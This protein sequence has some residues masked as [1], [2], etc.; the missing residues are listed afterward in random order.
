M[1]RY[2]FLGADWPVAITTVGARLKSAPFS[3]ETGDGFI[4]DRIR[5]DFVEGRHF[6][7]I[8][9]IEVVETPFGQQS[10]YER[11]TYR[12]VRF[13]LS[14][15]YPQIEMLNPPRTARTF[16]NRLAQTLDFR[17][18]VE[19]LTVSPIEW[20]NKMKRSM[21][22]EGFV[23]T[24][25]ISDLV[26]D[27]WTT[28]KIGLSGRRDVLETASKLIAKRRHNVEKVNLLLDT[29]FG[30]QG[31]VFSADGTAQVP[32]TFPEELCAQVRSIMPKPKVP[33][34]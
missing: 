17:V 12:E 20:A 10:T 15:N 32:D 13:R 4:V 33:K 16:L 2:K 21:G 27:E 25:Q 22:T 9:S 11:V 5:P 14:G 19:Q 8:V 1:K 24:I 6:E 18:A 7:K 3:E 28:A 30:K 34:T 23:Q 29:E 26:I 31:I